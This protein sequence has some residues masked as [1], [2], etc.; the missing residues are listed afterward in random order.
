MGEILLPATSVAYD[1]ETGLLRFDWKSHRSSNTQIA[2]IRVCKSSIPAHGYACSGGRV[3][4]IAAN[5]DDDDVTETFTLSAGQY[6]AQTLAAALQTMIRAS[7]SN[8]FDAFTVSYDAVSEKITVGNTKTFTM[9]FVGNALLGYEMGFGNNVEI[10]RGL[11]SQRIVPLTDTVFSAVE[12]DTDDF[13]IVGVNGIDLLGARMLRISVPSEATGV[14]YIE[15]SLGSGRLLDVVH[16]THE[17][18]THEQ[19]EKQYHKFEFGPMSVGDI[20]L[21]LTVRLPTGDTVPFNN[22]GRG[23]DIVLGL[24]TVR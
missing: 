14:G 18:N 13:R 24:L 12:V 20:F 15:E 8:A 9:Q 16:L 2:G 3:T 1:A 21:Q 5:S 17:T 7:S 4:I 23:F 11:T 19:M 6:T 22:R 10:N